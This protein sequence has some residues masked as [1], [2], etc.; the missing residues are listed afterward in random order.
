MTTIE[1][2]K[3]QLFLPSLSRLTDLNKR[4]NMQLQ[5]SVSV[6][7]KPEYENYAPERPH[8]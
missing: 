7:A 2:G 5:I 1:I 8:I 6:P 4:F 3:P